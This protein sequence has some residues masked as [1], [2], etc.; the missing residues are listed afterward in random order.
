MIRKENGFKRGCLGALMFMCISM[1]AVAQKSDAGKMEWFS[2][3]RLGIF[4]HWGIYSVNG[5]P[6]AF[7]E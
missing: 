4:I 5:I 6:E 7:P 1:T 2:D 3:A